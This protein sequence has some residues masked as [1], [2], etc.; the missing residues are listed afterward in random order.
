MYNYSEIIWKYV[1]IQNGKQV[2]KRI[3]ILTKSNLEQA[4]V[5]LLVTISYMYETRTWSVL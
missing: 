2:R 5:L 3:Y 4:N 1:A